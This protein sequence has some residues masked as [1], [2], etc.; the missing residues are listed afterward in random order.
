MF[1][2]KEAISVAHVRIEPRVVLFDD[3]AMADRDKYES[4]TISSESSVRE[5]EKL[6]TF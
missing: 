4:S 6:R 1:R 3:P 2:L 5:R